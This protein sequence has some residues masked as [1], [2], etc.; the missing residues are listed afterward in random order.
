M[1]EPDDIKVLH[2]RLRAMTPGNQASSL[3]WVCVEHVDDIKPAMNG[4]SKLAAHLGMTNGVYKADVSDMKAVGEFYQNQFNLGHCIA[5]DVVD[6]A[7]I[8]RLRYFSGNDQCAKLLWFTESKVGDFISAPDLRD[9]WEKR[10]CV[11]HVD[12]TLNT[13][14]D[15]MVADL[16]AEMDGILTKRIKLMPKPIQVIR[17]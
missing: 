11:M 10:G 15:K 3:W 1:M 13:A 8:K 7:T 2:R 9:V 5:G 4:I 17:R 16:K 6:E 14:A 12:A